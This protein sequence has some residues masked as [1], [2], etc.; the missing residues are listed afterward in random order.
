LVCTLGR[1]LIAD[2]QMPDAL[3]GGGEDSIAQGR[4]ERRQ[5]RLADP[6]GRDVNAVGDDPDMRDRRRF[7]D[8]EDL[9][10][11]EIVLLAS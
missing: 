3:A 5:P 7:V 1:Q 9:E 6:A 8:A 2:R 10:A 11:V 4:R